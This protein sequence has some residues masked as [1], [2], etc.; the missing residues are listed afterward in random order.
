MVLQPHC[1]Y[2]A[3]TETPDLL[4]VPGGPQW[5]R[6]SP[7]VELRQWLRD[8]AARSKRVA[9][10]CNRAFLLAQAGLL[11][12]RRATTHWNDVT[13]LA[14][15]FPKIHIQPDHIFVRDGHVY[16]SAG[17][18]AGID[19]ALHLVFEDFGAEV[20]L[21]VAKRLV[22]FTQRSGG[23]SQFSPYLAR[24]VDE[25]SVLRTVQNFVL[26]HLGTDLSVARLANA[27][28]MSERNFARVCAGS[29][30]DAGGFRRTCARRR[31]TRIARIF[32]RTAQDGRAPLRVQQPGTHACC[33]PAPFER[34]R[35]G[36]PPAL[37]RVP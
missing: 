18:S 11:D 34:E 21:N 12:G 22:V 19:L 15:K 3:R 36:L 4:L 28:S 16:T 27:A 24:Y 7:T 8:T 14:A 23:Q 32:Q 5:P 26:S 29:E 31:R 17:V 25:E 37:R 33:L 1:V 13:T 20:S 9:S 2:D 6:E 30:D 35:D 10:V